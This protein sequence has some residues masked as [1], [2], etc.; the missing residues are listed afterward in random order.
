[1]ES[2]PRVQDSTAPHAGLTLPINVQEKNVGRQE[3]RL[4]VI[5]MIGAIICIA[6]S[7]AACEMFNYNFQYPVALT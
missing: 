4:A 1:M 5:R 2:V 3:Q 6:G 7:V